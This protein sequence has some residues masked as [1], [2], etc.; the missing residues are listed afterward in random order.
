MALLA[1][2]D[3]WWRRAYSNLP[4]TL[5]QFALAFNII[6]RQE[7]IVILR[8]FIVSLAKDWVVG[9]IIIAIH[10]IVTLLAL[11]RL[12]LVVTEVQESNSSTGFDWAQVCEIVMDRLA[13]RV[14]RRF[15]RLGVF[16]DAHLLELPYIK[17]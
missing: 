1:K 2:T 16:Q 4:H 9:V 17:I 10:I 6:W 11:A 13:L 5:R 3:I 14:A 12:R 8:F 7:P 15:L